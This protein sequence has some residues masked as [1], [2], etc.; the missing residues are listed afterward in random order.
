MKKGKQELML[1]VG[2]VCRMSTQHRNGKL[3]IGIHGVAVIFLE[4]PH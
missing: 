1:V 3:I 4:F 2:E